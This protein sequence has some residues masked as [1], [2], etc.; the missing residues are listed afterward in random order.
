M[1]LNNEDISINSIIGAGTTIR[2][3]IKVNGFIRIDGDID[4]NLETSGNIIIG[5]KARIQGNIIAK[6]ITIGGIIKGNITAT[7]SVQL[8]SSSVVLGDILTHH[9]QADKDVVFHGHCIALSSETEY[10]AAYSKWQNIQAITNHSILQTSH[11]SHE[12]S[13]LDSSSIK[14][15]FAEPSSTIVEET[16]EDIT[17][18][19]EGNT[20]NEEKNKIF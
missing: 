7:D 4:G 18:N 14:K 6:S 20:I 1:A 11:V 9:I 10:N 2:G 15:Q 16:V 8:L 13:F 3:D 17:L 5:E 19:D 12:S